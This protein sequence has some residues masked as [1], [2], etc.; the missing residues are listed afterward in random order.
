MCDPARW[1]RDCAVDLAV[2]ALG[3][4]I[5]LN[6]WM[7]M[8]TSIFTFPADLA[9]LRKERASGMYRLS[10]YYAARTLSDVPMD[11]LIPSAFTVVTYW[12]SGL[13]LAAGSFFAYWAAMLLCVLVAQATGLLIGA[14]IANPRTGGA[15]AGKVVVVVV[16]P[17]RWAPTAEC[18]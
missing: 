16:M 13:R 1:R 9:I 3:S 4:Q 15:G 6:S 17:H 11:L 7:A 8:F 2:A 14:L 12:F 5:A 10:A 18:L